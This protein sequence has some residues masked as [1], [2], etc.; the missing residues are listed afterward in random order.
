[1]ERVAPVGTE[2][3]EVGGAHDS[4]VR[5]HERGYRGCNRATIKVGDGIVAETRQRRGEIF[6]DYGVARFGS[7]PV[8][9]QKNF[10]QPRIGGELGCEVL[11]LARQMRTCW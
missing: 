9:F 8:G 4:A 6:R 1:M 5:G 7:R 11:N 3:R 2:L 10:A